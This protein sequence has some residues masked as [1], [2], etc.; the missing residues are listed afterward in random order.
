MV[1]RGGSAELAK[2]KELSGELSREDSIEAINETSEDV[3]PS[4]L[5]TANPFAAELGKLDVSQSSQTFSCKT[6]VKHSETNQR[7]TR[8]K[9]NHAG[10]KTPTTSLGVFEPLEHSVYVGR[11]FLGSYERVS[12][13]RYAAYGPRGQCL[14][15]FPKRADALAA[16]DRAGGN[17]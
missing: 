2:I 13:R 16:I 1:P 10:Q 3:P 8:T 4:S 5:G 7:V 12:A 15:H 6:A 14:G 11:R 17:Q 9:Q